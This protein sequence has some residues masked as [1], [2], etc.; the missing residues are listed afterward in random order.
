MTSNG[1]GISIKFIT[2]SSFGEN[3]KN[4]SAGTN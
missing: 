1:G 2:I 4:I 3:T